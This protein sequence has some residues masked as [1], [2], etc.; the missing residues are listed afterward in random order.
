MV[1]GRRSGLGEEAIVLAG[2]LGLGRELWRGANPLVHEVGEYEE[3]VRTVW[4]GR[5]RMEAGGVGELFGGWRLFKAYEPLTM[6]QRRAFC[7]KWGI[8]Q[9]PMLCLR[10]RVS[11]AASL[12]PLAG[13]RRPVPAPPLAHHCLCANLSARFGFGGGR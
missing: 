2:L 11:A 13:Q 3:I 1:A 7:L 9:Q 4:E 6:S 8:A 5:K 12:N 10:S